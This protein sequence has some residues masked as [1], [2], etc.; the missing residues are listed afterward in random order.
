ML[1]FGCLEEEYQ[2]SQKKKIDFYV[3]VGKNGLRI[4]ESAFFFL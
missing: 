3:V 1:S 2:I 4:T